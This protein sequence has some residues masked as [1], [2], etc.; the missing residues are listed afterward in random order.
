[1]KKIF[2]VL[3]VVS[4]SLMMNAQNLLVNP[5][6]ESGLAPWAAGTSASYYA[7]SISTDA[8]TGTKSANYS[9]VPATTGFFQNVP[10][11]SGKSYKIT[12]WYKSVDGVGTRLW[13]VYK[14]AAGSAVYTTT[15]STTD[16]FR[17]SNQYISPATVWTQYSAIM[18][19]GTAV[20]NLDVAVRAYGGTTAFFDDF[21][22][23]DAALAVSD[24]SISKHAIVRNTSVSNTL[25]FAAKSD[26]QILN[27]AGQVVK[28][29]SVDNN[30]T[31]DISALPK[32]IY[33]VKGIVNGEESVQKVMKN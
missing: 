18:P 12:F 9:A 11:T 28:S 21:S 7:P 3:G 15:D 27:M 16:L 29:A 24:L 26:V 30:S 33:M 10:V 14:N 19:A 13:S 4:A 31:L 5:G 1:M 6:F 20:T 32:G 17:T 23:T 8:H 25:T 22:V 2:T